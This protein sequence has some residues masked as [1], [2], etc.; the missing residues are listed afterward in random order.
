MGSP[1]H[2]AALIGSG[3]VRDYEGHLYIG[4][5]SWI[6][7]LVPWK[8]T[9]LFHKI[10]SLPAGIPGRYQVLNEQDIA[11]G[12]V[13]YLLDNLILYQNEF[14]SGKD[15]EDPYGK[16]SRIADR[17]PAGSDR[18]IFTPW[19]NGERAPVDDSSLRGCFF[20]MSLRTTADHFVRAVFEGVAYNTKWSF[21]YVEKFIKRKME[22][23]TIIGG[24][25]VSDVW[26]QIFADVLDRRIQRVSHAR[27][28]NARGAAF[29]ASASLHHIEFSDI[30][31]LMEYERVFEPNPKNRQI[32]DELFAVFLLLY[33]NNRNVFKRLNHCPH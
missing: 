27:E 17:I 9:D 23:L 10:A 15:P 20:N 19:L 22:M 6:E 14:R 31:D 26:C 16:L 7:C 13:S 33:K 1:D 4:T 18:L 24:G 32:Y 11:G 5:S 21:H 29:Q 12:C 25:A 8:K 28:T 2:Q 30:P 3:A